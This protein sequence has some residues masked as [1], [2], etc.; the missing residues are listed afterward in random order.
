MCADFSDELR[1]RAGLHQGRADRVAKEIVGDRLLAK[2]DLSFRG[3]N[4]DIDFGVR[5]L[6]KK[7]HDGKNRRRKN[8][9]IGLG[10]RVLDDAVANEASINERVDGIAI[11]LLDLR[12]G[13]EAV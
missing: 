11:E 5:H 8:V 6:E 2:A 12:L 10:E 7:E 13:D 3:M 4:I 1:Y 9:A